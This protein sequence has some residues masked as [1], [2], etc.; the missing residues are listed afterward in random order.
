MGA[1]PP[2]LTV[3]VA[4]PV[5]DEED[6][7]GDC[8]RAVASQTYPGIIEV[9]VIDGGSKDRT[10][11]LAAAHPGV[12]LLDN[13]RRIQAAALNLALAEAKGDVFV[14]VDG[15]CRVAPDYVQQCVEALERT[16]AAMVGGAMTPVVEGGPVRR[17]IAAAMTSPLGA[18]PAS[19][20]RTNGTGRWV[21]TVY[22]GAYRSELASELGGYDGDLAVNEDAELAWRMRDQGGI[23]FD[24]S[25]RSSYVP[26]A[27]LTAVARQFWRYGQ[28][29]ATTI[30]KHPGS[31]SPRQM[32]P[33]LLVLGLLSPVRRP[34][35]A[36]Y[37]TVV[38]AGAATRTRQ[39]A[40]VAAGFALVVPTMHLAWGA[41][42]LVGLVRRQ[43]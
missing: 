18:G 14:R 39:G 41:G 22:L 37:A 30:R 38:A 21:D 13:P 33:P 17:A 28:G 3:T 29:R 5:L 43:R 2:G 15:H 10:R 24:P 11:A 8:L 31:L 19:F 40:G 26:R 7:I 27:S 34:V 4:V 23:W 25:I 32:L 12:R 42:A 35:A 1:S 16:G 36:A 9:L 6:H 20:H